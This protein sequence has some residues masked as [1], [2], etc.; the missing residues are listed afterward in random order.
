M[1]IT[2]SIPADAVL[3]ADRGRRRSAAGIATR[4]RS[5]EALHN[6]WDKNDPK[7]AQV[8]LH[9]LKVRATPRYHDPTAR[10]HQRRAG[11]V[12]DP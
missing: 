4:T 8:T 12:K 2:N 9:M 6:S 5:P 11:A 1:T 7:D 3:I 10:R